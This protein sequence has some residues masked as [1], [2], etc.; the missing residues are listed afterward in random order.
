MPKI[1]V[2]TR[3]KRPIVDSTEQVEKHPP[4]NASSSAS[5]YQA[6]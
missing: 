1:S 5:S 6:G 4:K 3:K 2:A